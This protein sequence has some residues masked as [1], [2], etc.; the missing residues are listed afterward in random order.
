L[1]CALTAYHFR[2]IERDKTHD[3]TNSSSGTANFSLVIGGPFYQLLRRAHLTG[4]ALEQLPRRILFFALVTCPA[5]FRLYGRAM[6]LAQP[7]L[8]LKSVRIPWPSMF[9]NWAKLGGGVERWKLFFT[10]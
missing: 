3:H 6:G 4:P 5:D 2:H 8:L 10:P 9:Q 7:G 1:R